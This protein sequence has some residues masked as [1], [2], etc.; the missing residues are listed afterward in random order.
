MKERL[1]I[2]N[3]GPIKEADLTF[4][5]FNVL[6]GEQATGK[7]TVAKLMCMCRFFSY[8][9]DFDYW[10]KWGTSFSYGMVEWGLEE[11]VRPESRIEFYCNDYELVGFPQEL[12]FD[13]WTGEENNT[14]KYEIA[15]D[16]KPKSER[17]KHLLDALDEL[18]VQTWFNKRYSISETPPTF[19]KNNVFG[20]NG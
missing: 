11:F 14:I 17:F 18:N 16:L 20:S 15:I 10:E 1:I 5:R 13:P 6:I 19:F 7:S 12:P 4:G 8:I 3:F 9:V 2:K